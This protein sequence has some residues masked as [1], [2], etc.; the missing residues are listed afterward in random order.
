MSNRAAKHESVFIR[1]VKAPFRIL[2]RARDF[3]VRSL[4]DCSGRMSE[5]SVIVGYPGGS[6][7]IVP[8]SFS[9][10]SSRSNDDE[11]IK[12]LMRAASQRGLREKLEM[13]IQQ[14]QQLSKKTDALPRSRTVAIGRIDEDKPCDF[15]EDLKTKPDLL[16]P[17][18]KSY[19]V[20]KKN[21]SKLW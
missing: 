5:A 19:A 20:S 10:N 4:T 16:Y 2:G 7:N 14:L 9:V 21:T 1:C 3:Y 12:E 6:V 18:S 13:E 11:D 15:D 17:R 8:R